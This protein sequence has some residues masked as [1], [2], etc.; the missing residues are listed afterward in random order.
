MHTRYVDGRP[1]YQRFTGHCRE[2]EGEEHGW[3]RVCE[4]SSHVKHRVYNTAALFNAVN[5]I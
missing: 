3:M 2:L 5:M 1:V 4:Y